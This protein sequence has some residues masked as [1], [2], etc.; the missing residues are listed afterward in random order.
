MCDISA[1]YLPFNVDKNLHER[2]VQ[3]FLR[4]KNYQNNLFSLKIGCTQDL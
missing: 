2:R 4:N 1:V 3:P